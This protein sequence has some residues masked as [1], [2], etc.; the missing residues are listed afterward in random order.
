MPSY[1]IDDADGLELEWLSNAQTI[2]VSAGASAP[3]EL[4]DELIAKLGQ[5]FHIKVRKFKGVEENV[6]FKLPPEIRDVRSEAV[7][8]TGRGKQWRFL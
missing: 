6:Q 2:G 8:L 3:E 5:N 7:F 1:L 4:L